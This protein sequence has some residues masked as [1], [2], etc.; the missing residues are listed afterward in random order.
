MNINEINF[1]YLRYLKRRPTQADIKAHIHKNKN[2]FEMEVKTCSEYNNLIC[3]QANSITIVIPTRNRNHTFIRAINSC[4]NQTYRNI[5]I[6]IC[7]DSDP[8]YTLTQ[9]Y[10]NST[11]IDNP[12][13]TYIKNPK[14]LG[15]CKNINQGLS[16]AKG[17]FVALLFD[18][19]FF[20][21]TYIMETIN[22][23]KQNSLIGFVTTAAHNFINDKYAENTFY[24]NG[25]RFSGL[26]HKNYYYN[27]IVNLYR[28]PSYIVWSV[29]PCN[30]VFRNNNILLREKLYDGFDEKQL[31]CG[32]G[33]DL[34]FILDNIKLYNYFYVNPEHLVCFDSTNGSFSIDNMTYVL[35]RMD[36]TI[37]Y[38]L[39][40]EL[41]EPNILFKIESLNNGTN[42]KVPQNDTNKKYVNNIKI[43]N[44]LIA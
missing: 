14:N 44:L 10:Y 12:N 41:I 26:L 11:H 23:F 35:D 17:T 7:D 6:I 13:V 4:L 25:K 21:E 28:S 24:I 40:N 9:E 3:N 43:K 37:K 5:E 8:D 20:Y 15:F 27:G 2:D 22:I 29:S 36:I 33:Y 30:Y 19:D 34:L 38:W 31:K 42:E 39:E 18:D 16:K 1:I 32:A